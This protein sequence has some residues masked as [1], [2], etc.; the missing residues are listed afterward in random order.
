VLAVVLGIGDAGEVAVA[1]PFTLAI[2]V[3]FALSI[4]FWEGRGVRAVRPT[5]YVTAGRTILALVPLVVYAAASEQVSPLVLVGA[6]VLAIG[7]MLEEINVPIGEGAIPV[8]TNLP[9]VHVRNYPL[10]PPSYLYYVDLAATALAGVLAF[11]GAPP[12]LFLVVASV[13]LLANV[14]IAADGSWRILGRKRVE[15]NLGKIVRDYGP[16]FVLHWDAPRGGEYQVKMW[17]PVLEKLDKRF[18][19]I[20]RN[21]LTFRDVAQSTNVPVV[22]R[23]GTADL[24]ALPITSLRTAFYVNTALRNNHLV[25]FSHIAHIQLNHGDSD[26]GPSYS[27]TFRM[28]DRNFVAGQAAIDRF[29]KNGVDVPR[30]M[31]EI[32]GRPQVA[33]V[34]VRADAVVPQKP[35]VLYAP[36]WSGF[37]ED[38]NYSSLPQ[39]PRI[40]AALLERGCR[41]VFRP[42]PFAYKNPDLR[43]G[44]RE[45]AAM[46]ARDEART[47]R[48]H[49]WGR[50]AES[51]MSI[52]DC[53]NVSDAMIS[54]VSSVVSDYLFSEKPFAVCSMLPGMSTEAFLADFPLARGAYVLERDGKNLQS[55]L[56]DLLGADPLGDE[57][58]ALRTY[59]L[60]DF[61]SEGYEQNFLRIARHYI[62]RPVDKLSG[63]ARA[64]A[65]PPAVTLLEAGD[66]IDALDEPSIID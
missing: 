51:R 31:F 61:P 15:R 10:F 11:L 46:L 48:G 18:L 33:D 23:Q 25:R 3:A 22:L 32:V 29:E 50:E 45:I 66:D 2:L 30:E 19:V 42:H 26:K 64:V 5:G 58:R 54:D 12:A 63:S 55:V 52:V 35:T 34:R 24:E 6:A 62:E 36:T 53:F 8:S 28:F 20:V 17:I 13:P 14:V 57:R 65:Q 59:Y 39:G 41:V 60:G 43:R 38:A 27:P 7:V 16:E 4:R 56:D 37:F 40:V 1:I 49:I 9:G 47:G 44:L 21:A